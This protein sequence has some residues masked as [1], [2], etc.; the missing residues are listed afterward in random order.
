M[1]AAGAP[2]ISSVS[3]FVITLPGVPGTADFRF[4]FLGFPGRLQT[5]RDEQLW[6]RV[7]PRSRTFP[8]SDRALYQAFPIE[9]SAPRSTFAGLTSR[10]VTPRARERRPMRSRPGTKRRKEG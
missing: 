9:Q 7:A 8:S 5:P 6:P 2:A 10:C 4:A 1:A 3:G